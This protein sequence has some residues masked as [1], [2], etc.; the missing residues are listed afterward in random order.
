MKLWRA[1]LR[2]HRLTVLMLVLFTGLFAVSFAL[3]GLPLAA[4]AYRRGCV[5]WR[6]LVWRYGTSGGRGGGIRRWSSCGRPGR[7]CWRPCR[8]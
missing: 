1:Y 3:Y 8:R 6:A 5:R 2:Q 7:R 4:V